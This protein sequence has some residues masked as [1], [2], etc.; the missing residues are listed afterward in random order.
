MG[1]FAPVSHHHQSNLLPEV[2]HSSDKTLKAVN[3]Q[4]APVVQKTPKQQAADTTADKALAKK[5]ANFGRIQIEYGRARTPE[6]RNNIKEERE[7]NR[8][9]KMVNHPKGL[10]PNEFARLF[11]VSY[12]AL[13][14]NIPSFS[15]NPNNRE[16]IRSNQDLHLMWKFINASLTKLPLEFRDKRHLFVNNAFDFPIVAVPK[17]ND[18]GTPVIVNGEVQY[19]EG[20]TEL[21]AYEFNTP[22]YEGTF[23]Q[24]KPIHQQ[25]GLNYYRLGEQAA[26]KHPDGNFAIMI[27]SRGGKL[28]KDGNLLR[29]NKTY[30]EKVAFGAAA[31][32]GIN[33]AHAAATGKTRTP[34]ADDSM[35]PYAVERSLDDVVNR[36]KRQ[37]VPGTK[38]GEYW[39]PKGPIVITG[40]DNM[41]MF[42]LRKD[43]KQST[44][45]CLDQYL[46]PTDGQTSPVNEDNLRQFV[47]TYIALDKA[48][49][50]AETVAAKMESGMTAKDADAAADTEVD[51]EFGRIVTGP[52]KQYLDGEGGVTGEDVKTQLSAY[53]AQ[54]AGENQTTPIMEVKDGI[55]LVGGIPIEATVGCLNAEIIRDFA[56]LPD[57]HP[58]K[59]DTG[60][61]NGTN[62]TDK[63]IGTNKGLFMKA[64][65]GYNTRLR[66]LGRPINAR[67]LEKSTNSG[68]VERAAGE[69]KAAA[70]DKLALKM[71]EFMQQNKIDGVPKP[72]N[73]ANGVGI[74]R[75]PQN[76]SLPLIR[77]LCEHAAKEVEKAYPGS[78]GFPWTVMGYNKPHTV[79][80]KAA[81]GN[82]YE[83]ETELRATSVVVEIEGIPYVGTIPAIVKKGPLMPQPDIK[84]M[85]D[86]E[87]VSVERM[88]KCNVTLNFE[89]LSDEEK[90]HPDALTKFVEPACNEATLKKYGFSVDDAMNVAK[91]SSGM[92][93][94]GIEESMDEKEIGR[95]KTA[96]ELH[97]ATAEDT[98]FAISARKWLGQREKNVRSA[99]DALHARAPHLRVAVA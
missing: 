68:M 38:P 75:I 23:S 37:Q 14:S 44:K 67:G 10:D 49:K 58:S 9:A 70:L 7:I 91:W 50:K 35:E 92:A 18:D 5:N 47:E 52:L 74:I 32:K 71:Q 13:D 3:K 83:Y 79:K 96:D 19:E 76:A 66:E 17:L 55:T 98:R 86:G 2:A 30:P 29:Q 48:E 78:D 33:A 42:H 93:L 89:S 80:E 59:L 64:Q 1:F 26:K 46:K 54:H 28:D 8:L 16:A 24:P 81:D 6:Q 40:Y 56:K 12:T 36:I 90:K 77:A 27:G 57:G 85:V 51:A 65:N 11:D 15:S 62:V 39:P 53:L 43:L 41:V 84:V 87:E 99:M 4:A 94:Y 72:E 20:R 88:P 63:G 31:E 73:A 45:Q 25:L 82:E 95:T 22:T 60:K 34:A 61:F 69:S 97:D 21:R